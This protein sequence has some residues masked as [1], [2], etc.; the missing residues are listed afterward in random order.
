VRIEPRLAAALATQFSRRLSSHAL[1]MTN[2]AA[3]IDSGK[4]RAPIVKRDH[5]RA[6]RP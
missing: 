1:D 6:K 5:A 4:E 3:S 2:F